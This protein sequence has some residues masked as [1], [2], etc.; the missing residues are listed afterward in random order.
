M[1]WTVARER[2]SIPQEIHSTHPAMKTTLFCLLIS[3]GTSVMSLTYAEVG[4][5][6][7]A[8][9]E[10]PGEDVKAK[11]REGQ[12]RFRAK[13]QEQMQ[14]AMKKAA[15]LESEGKK[16]E[17]EA[18]RREARERMAASVEKHQKM[19]M[20][21]MQELARGE[22]HPKA[23]PKEALRGKLEHVEQ[24][25]AHLREAGLMEEAA[26]LKNVA[27]HLRHAMA[28]HGEQPRKPDGDQEHK[29]HPKHPA[30]EQ[31]AAREK[32][33]PD[34]DGLRGEVE[35]LRHQMQELQHL[36]KKLREDDHRGGKEHGD[37]QK[38]DLEKDHKG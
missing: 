17:A 35:A 23:A 6:P 22:E 4:E 3:L 36:M 31:K 10:K 5:K 11:L 15:Q 33:H 25:I 21:K 18:V 26:H 12:E 37:P 9:E 30:E 16:E 8:P 27:E 29:E 2:R 7:R 20:E 38:G 13:M 19:M 34:N 24:A 1:G 14:G 28:E 32:A